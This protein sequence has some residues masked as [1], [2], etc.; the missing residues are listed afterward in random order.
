MWKFYLKN[1]VRNILKNK[2]FSIINTTGLS[3][4]I[5]SSILIFLWV[6]D[7]ISFNR[8]YNNSDQIY[9]IISEERSSKS[10]D[11]FGVTTLPALPYLLENY[12]EIV[13]GT[14]TLPMPSSIEHKE[15]AFN[16]RFLR[17]VD[18]S[19]FTVFHHN[20]IYGDPQKPFTDNN[21]IVITDKIAKKYFEEE[22]PIGKI[23]TIKG[24][25]QFKVTAVVEEISKNTT[26]AYQLLVPFVFC[27]TEGYALDD[28][29]R[30]TVGTYVVLDKNANYKEVEAKISDIYMQHDDTT[31]IDDYKYYAH[32]QSIEDIRLYE[33]S[34][35]MG[36]IR[37]VYIFSIL[38]IF[39][40][41]IACINF[42]N[43]ATAQATKRAKEVGIKKV[44]GAHRS[45]LIKQFFIES[46]IQVI[47][48]FHIAIV[49][50]ELLRPQF[51]SI[52]GKEI[53]LNYLEFEYI[54]ASIIIIGVTSFL[55]G[56]YPS[57]LLTSFVPVKTIKGRFYSKPRR[58]STR[59]I[60]VLFQFLISS[61]LIICTLTIYLQ[62]TYLQKR[63]IGI[64][65]ENI[66]F[67][68]LNNRIAKNFEFFK[69]KLKQNTNIQ[70]VAQLF[71][72]PS[73]YGMGMI[74]NSDELGINANFD[75]GIGDEE[76][77]HT[78]D[79][80]LLEGENFTG[81]YSIDSNRILINETAAKLFD[82]N[83]IGSKLSFVND[84][85][86]SGIVKDFNYRPSSY[87]VGPL[88]LISYNKQYRKIAVRYKPN[89]MKESVDYIEKVYKEFCPNHSFDYNVFSDDFEYHLR[90]EKRMI[91]I[92][93][94][95]TILG[96]LISCLGLLGLSSY[97]AEQRTKEIG[98]RRVN[99][100]SLWNIFNLLNTSY[101][102]LVLLGFL[103][104]TI[105]AYFILNTWLKEFA[106]KIDMPWWAFIF[107]GLI[108]LAIAFAT[109]SIFAYKASMQ[110]PANS[111]RYE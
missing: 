31:N 83:P 97:M 56:I 51:N 87:P 44:V 24:N 82:K 110:N 93:Q 29:N 43:L 54:L 107:S 18:T 27:E 98:I 105:P 49:I 9:K 38:A 74:V 80:K 11:F 63:D 52:T 21:S 69:E 61:I 50:V 37:Y 35:K 17:A 23:L 109:M 42:T 103:A 16:E 57:I 46:V 10:E 102:S 39:I 20:F 68:N 62:L 48:A 15:K 55:S 100:A 99:G 13:S 5:A 94:Y 84:G 4:G 14:R 47:L 6:K 70:S 7:E 89:T 77:I 12:P 58:I 33:P 67:F 19:F 108:S 59:K 111:L 34:G 64:Q 73:F 45:Q 72:M 2:T 78:F 91:Q 106:Y 36:Q 30:Y 3:V 104:A 85:Y 53:E 1:A 88:A 65:K 22:N 90:N 25:Y 86:I 95:F 26:I 101:L 71:Q 79:I 81:D 40:L 75:V 32:L 60:L 8:C 41:I 92:I 96:I 76:L 28:W 66:I